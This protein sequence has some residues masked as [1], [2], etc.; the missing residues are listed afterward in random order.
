MHFKKYSSKWDEDVPTDERYLD[1]IYAEIGMN[2][3]AYGFAKF[4]RD[5]LLLGNNSELPN[6]SQ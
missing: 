1:N 3:G 2:S 4:N 5:K 6:S